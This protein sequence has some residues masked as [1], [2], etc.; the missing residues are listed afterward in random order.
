MPKTKPV[1]LMLFF[2]C[3]QMLP[4]HFTCLMLSRHQVL[5]CCHIK[6]YYFR[7]F[8]DLSLFAEQRFEFIYETI[9]IRFYLCM[10]MY[11][12]IP[13]YIYIHIL[14][15]YIYIYIYIL[16]LFNISYNIAFNISFHL[17]LFYLT[18]HISFPFQK[19]N[20]INMAPEI[21]K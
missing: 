13:V 3:V 19:E 17:L 9:F 21:N 14:C 7:R 10:Y 20:Q 18:L 11:K 2:K 12:C 16:F 8:C 5:S 4:F 15:I 6:N 1:S